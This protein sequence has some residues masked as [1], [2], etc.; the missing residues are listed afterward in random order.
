MI[1]K[2]TLDKLNRLG[3]GADVDSLETYISLIETSKKMDYQLVEENELDSLKEILKELK[4]E[5]PMI[6]G[7]SLL[8]DYCTVKELT[9]LDKKYN[10][11]LE[12]YGCDRF[13]I[14]EEQSDLLRA[15]QIVAGVNKSI[16]VTA[17]IK[18]IG[19]PF[20]AIYTNGWLA[21]GIAGNIDI[22][23]EIKDVLPNY[24]EDWGF[25]KF[26]EVRGILYISKDLDL[27]YKNEREA[28]VD[29]VINNGNISSLGAKYICYR[30][31]SDEISLDSIL[32][33][34]EFLEDSGFEV[35]KYGILKNVTKLNL[36][37]SVAKLL[38]YFG[39]VE[40]EENLSYRS[41]GLLVIM[42]ELSDL[43]YRL[44]VN[45]HSFLIRLGI[46]KAEQFKAEI[47]SIEFKQG[48]TYLEPYAVI[49]NV[50]TS[51]GIV[52]RVSLVSLGI[53]EE[54]EYQVGS[55][56]EFKVEEDAVKLVS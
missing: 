28:I 56:I 14:V 6:T 44:D 31:L 50:K 30:L 46:W 3:F 49:D 39:S 23:R 33:E 37:A 35:P 9:G 47:K 4:P 45:K 53:M 20:R 24:I 36:E 26:V 21:K 54:N 2:N 41:D 10:V 11:L 5:S 13:N 32:E 17:L 22:T 16:S 12:E 48:K 7:S 38:Q 27:R 18:P 52:D 34:I 15:K 42:N 43:D 1:N 51:I 8:E 19:L 55:E 40:K 29:I 25:F